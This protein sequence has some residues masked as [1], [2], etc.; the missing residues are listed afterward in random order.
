VPMQHR[1]R[2]PIEACWSPSNLIG[3]QAY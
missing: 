1:S 3:W 2:N